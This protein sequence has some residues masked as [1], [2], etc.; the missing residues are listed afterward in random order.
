VAYSLSGLG[1]LLCD[2]DQA[3]SA[4][5]DL[6]DALESR[7]S[8]FA[9]GHHLT[10]GSASALARCLVL[11]NQF[12][13]A[14]VVLTQTLRDAEQGAAY[15]RSSKVLGEAM[16]ALYE[17]WNRLD[18]VAKWREALLSPGNQRSTNFPTP[19]TP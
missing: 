3:Q 15:T 4:E 14:E 7:R 2:H 12:E 19:P 5:Q 8:G 9:I 10:A 11:Q 1:Q 13:Q 17:A 16:V 18:E 6:R